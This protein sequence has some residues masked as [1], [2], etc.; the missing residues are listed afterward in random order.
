MSGLDLQFAVAELALLSG[1]RIAKI[2]RTD[3]GIFLFKIGDR[4]LLFEPGVRLHLTMQSLKAADSPDGFTAFLRKNFE[5]KTADGIRQ[6]GNDRILEIT[7]RS[8]ERLVFELFRKGDLIAVGEDGRIAACL[9]KEEAGGRKIAKGEKYEYPK[10]TPFEIRA[11][12]KAAFLVQT[13]GKGEPLSFSLDAE[14]G[15]REFPSFSDALDFYYANQT[16]ESEEEARARERLSG[17]EARLKSQEGALLKIGEERAQ[18][19]ANGDAIWQELEEMDSLISLVREMKK[20]GKKDGEINAALSSRRAK[21]SG[22]EIE[23]G[24]GN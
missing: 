19:K 10:A 24:I 14:K 5:G 6:H 11:P 13:G 17:L 20:A 23:I 16:R 3:E 4:E 1:K 8:K 7:T 22:A 12:K 9:Q 18:A 2:R 21:L 15:G